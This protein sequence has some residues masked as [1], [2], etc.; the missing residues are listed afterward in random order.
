MGTESHEVVA[1]QC[2]LWKGATGRALC[3]HQCRWQLC[4]EPQ[5]Q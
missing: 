5:E 4:E 2:H 1:W 3:L